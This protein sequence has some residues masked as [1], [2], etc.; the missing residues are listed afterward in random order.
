MKRRTAFSLFEPGPRRSYTVVVHA[1]NDNVISHVTKWLLSMRPM[2]PHFSICAVWNPCPVVMQ[3]YWRQGVLTSKFSTPPWIGEFNYPIHIHSLTI[4]ALHIWCKKTS[5]LGFP[6]TPT[7]H[8]SP[9]NLWRPCLG[10]GWRRPEISRRWDDLHWWQSAILSNLFPSCWK[11]L[12]L[13]PLSKGCPPFKASKTIMMHLW[14]SA[15]SAHA[16]P[17]RQAL[18]S[19]PASNFQPAQQMGGSNTGA[20]DSALSP[21]LPVAEADTP[22]VASGMSVSSPVGIPLRWYISIWPHSAIVRAATKFALSSVNMC[23]LWA[24]LNSLQIVYPPNM[25]IP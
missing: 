9:I 22:A 1:T 17:G 10:V 14:N 20:S 25:T 11:S 19:L 13:G 5:G 24:G 23:C 21:L 4:I 2:S 16:A 15:A 6:G 7:S 8:I 3:L 12:I 18:S